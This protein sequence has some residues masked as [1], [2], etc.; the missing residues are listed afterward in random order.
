[1]LNTQL[2][3]TVLVTPRSE[4]KSLVTESTVSPMWKILPK[5]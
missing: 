3:D 5:Y 4:L 1:M 2:H